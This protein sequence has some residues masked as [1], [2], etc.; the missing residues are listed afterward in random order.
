MFE[1]KIE[2][3]ELLATLT[4]HLQKQNIKHKPSIL[5]RHKDDIFRFRVVGT[6]LK[7]YV[8][9]QYMQAMCFGRHLYIY[10]CVDDQSEKHLKELNPK[11]LKS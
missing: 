11:N 9:K 4:E 6:D 1:R 2:R 5:I 3:L 8:Y 7:F 10:A